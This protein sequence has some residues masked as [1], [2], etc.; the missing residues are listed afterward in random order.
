FFVDLPDAEARRAI[1]DIHL[2][3]RSQ[4]PAKL[5]VD[6]LVQAADQFSGAEIEQ[7]IVSSLYTAFAETKELDGALVLK[8]IA[9]T[10]PLA[11]TMSERVSALREWARERTVAAN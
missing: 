6:Q 4:D 11:H 5:P 2:R 8:E 3:K 9:A 10:R 1:F 7:V